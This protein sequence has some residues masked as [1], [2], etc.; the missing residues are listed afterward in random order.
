MPFVDLWLRLR[1]LLLRRRAERDMRDELEFHVE[2]QARK[3]REAGLSEAD[4]NSRARAQFGSRAHV[5]DQCRDARGTA[6]VDAL[7]RDILYAFRTFRRAPLAAITIIATIALGL[8]LVTIVFTVYNAFFLRVDE[9]RNP[10]ELFA[11]ERATGP[12]ERQAGPE[13]NIGPPFTRR[14]YE[15]MRRDTT[16]FT[17]IFAM[18]RPVRTRVDGRRV[19]SHL[20][21]GNFFHALGVQAMLG[22]SLTPEDDDPFAPRPVIVLSH[23]GWNQLFAGDPAVIGRSL[24][25]NGLPYEVVGV[26]PDGFRGLAI[27]PP[28]YWAPLALA[29]QF[30]GGDDKIAV[31]VPARASCASCSRRACCSLSRPRHAVSPYRGCS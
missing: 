30:R 26:M 9:V 17:D 4:A 24:T 22:R 20:V 8:G 23:R 25:I 13:G 7:A 28:A 18:I 31:A 16:V 5:E 19:S 2:M 15:A 3:L 1:A 11:V 12:G 6:F 21:T 29:P 10:G 14:D 27:G